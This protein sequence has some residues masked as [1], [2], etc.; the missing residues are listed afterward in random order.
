MDTMEQYRIAVKD[1]ASKNVDYLFHNEGNE[2]ALII[3]TNIFE[4]AK[5]HIRIAANQLYND[6]VVNT[7]AYVNAIKAFLDKGDTRLSVIIT[8][9]PEVDEVRR[10]SI[11]N[12]LY[13]MLYN[14]KAYRQRRVIIKEGN[15]KSFYDGKNQQINFCT[16]DVKMY[17]L[18]DDIEN[19]K[20]VANF[21]DE[22]TTT[23]FAEKFD[24]VFSELEE[25]NLSDYY[26]GC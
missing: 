2:H 23:K 15:G 25:V 6:E 20:A 10:R 17:R 1:Y 9:R 21:G 14:H 24:T 19:R 5:D 16:G 26:Q 18:E 13:W 7:E 4:N 3:L 22:E 8:K 12:T 11:K